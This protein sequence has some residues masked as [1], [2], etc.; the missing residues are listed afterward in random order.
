MPPHPA[1]FLGCVHQGG[2]SFRANRAAGELVRLD[3]AD[4][5]GGLRARKE[6]PAS[7]LNN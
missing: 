5:N 2:T 4:D 1:H 3:E 6:D 7:Y